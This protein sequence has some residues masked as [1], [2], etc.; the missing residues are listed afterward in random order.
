MRAIN[1]AG[2]LDH[3]SSYTLRVD[4]LATAD[5]PEPTV[6]AESEPVGQ[7]ELQQLLA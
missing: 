5:A 4:V 1:L 3:G 2:S 6:P 7:A